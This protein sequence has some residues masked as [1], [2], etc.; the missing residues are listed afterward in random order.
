MPEVALTQVEADALIAMEKHRVDSTVY[1]YPRPG[2]SIRVPLASPDQRERFSLDVYRGLINLRK[3]T[4]QNRGRS[5]VILM[6]LDIEGGPH[7]NPDGTPL[8]CPHLHLYREGYGD[9]WAFPVPNQAFSDL[10]DL[11]IMLEDFMRYC[12]VTLPPMIQRGLFQ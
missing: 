6:R 8:P 4:Y 2:E 3:V 10:T 9:K 7:R 5:V 11:W 1:N 12:N